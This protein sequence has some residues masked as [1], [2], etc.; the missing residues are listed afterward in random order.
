MIDGR[1]PRSIVDLMAAELSKWMVSDEGERL[2]PCVVLGWE[3]SPW[4]EWIR[5]GPRLKDEYRRYTSEADPPWLFWDQHQCGGYS[6]LQVVWL[7]VV[8]PL[9]HNLDRGQA[10][11]PLVV[12]TLD[13]LARDTPFDVAARQKLPDI[14]GSLHLTAR[15]YSPTVL[16]EL[17]TFLSRGF[18]MPPVDTGEEAWIRFRPCQLNV[19]FSS[20][21]YLSQANAESARLDGDWRV[22]SALLA[23]LRDF[24]RDKNLTEPRAFL[25]WHNSD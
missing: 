20:F 23:Q 3:F 18:D 5:S 22:D 15:A 4:Y 14:V 12:S 7:G 11:A 16:R 25:A 13:A 2:L 10:S 8:L 1:F 17:E 9:V 21:R 6:C 24:G 19:H